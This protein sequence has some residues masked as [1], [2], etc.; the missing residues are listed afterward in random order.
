[1]NKCEDCG[2]E[3]PLLEVAGMMLCQECITPP[4]GVPHIVFLIDHV[5]EEVH[6]VIVPG[7]AINEHGD[8]RSAQELEALQ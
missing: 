5:R 4:P 2:R 3:A 8:L 7:E 6:S 1:M